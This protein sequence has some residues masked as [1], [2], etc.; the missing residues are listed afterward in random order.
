MR[1]WHVAENSV[2]DDLIKNNLNKNSVIFQLL[3]AKG[4]SASQIDNFLQA[5]YQ[6]NLHD[7]F[8]FKDMLPASELILK[9][10]QAGN[11]ITVYGD[12][13]A[14]GVTSTAVMF[15][16]LDFL[17]NNAAA[18]NKPDIYI[19]HRETE[20]YGLN[21]N[22]VE[23]IAKGGTKLIITVDGG[24]RSI[25][26]VEKAKELGMDV[27]V[28][29]HHEPGEKLPNCL[30]INPKVDKDNYPFSGLAGVGVAFK[31]A[32]ALFAVVSQNKKD[33]QNSTTEKF[34]FFEKWLL[35]LVAI[36]T[37]AD[38]VP[39]VDE[40][41]VLVKYGLLILNKT[42]RV[43][44]QK[45]IEVSQSAVDKKGNTR[46]LDT[47]QVGF[48]LAPR[49]N[50][51][52]RLG[53]ASNAYQ[54]LVTTDETEAIKIAEELNAT[55]QERQNLTEDIFRL[56]DKS[57]TKEAKI[58]F[59]VCPCIREG[60]EGLEI[61]QQKSDILAE[62]VWPAGVMGLVAGKLTEKYYLPA[63]AITRKE[64]SPG[65]F[66]IVGSAR[67]IAEFN[68]TAMLEKCSEFLKNYGGHKQAAGFTVKDGELEKF[69]ALA[70]KI[71]GDELKNVLLAPTLEI[72]LKIN[73]G[74]ISEELYN[75]L[76][77]LRPFGVQNPQPK[78]LTENLQVV[79][80][81]TMGNTSQH[82]KLKLLKDGKMFDAVAFGAS[83]E[84]KKI[85]AG[86]FIDLV[87]YIDINEW[88]GRR[89]VQLKA[90]DLKKRA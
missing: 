61:S 70:N 2:S 74:E 5:E 35:D 50:A 9:H 27:I 88:N 77:K 21:V 89:E 67:S 28:T 59:A 56:A 12:Y 34:E 57:I 51:A 25:T 24:I 14:D 72:D 64:S 84:W 82:L 90:V 62:H 8:L 32:Q 85:T 83:D 78:F 87:Y 13:D 41:R 80:A 37:I 52:G 20:G 46:E 26:E 49:L 33:Y 15:K 68:I 47:W 40:N 79:N 71:A 76:N 7:P 23:L 31:V 75:T 60:R 1:K 86:D 4:F 16:T 58:I 63:L 29:D 66:E 42:R 3:G 11:K 19:P 45:L 43:G 10:L 53:H 55:N 54:L 69:L 22:A 81:N 6:A 44:I 36:G 18:E 65:V 48:Q 38:L 17:I 39:L 73:F 30:I